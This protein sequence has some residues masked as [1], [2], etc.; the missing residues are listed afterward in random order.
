MSS[1]PYT[2]SDDGHGYGDVDDQSYIGGDYYDDYG[3]LAREYS[4]DDNLLLGDDVTSGTLRDN[5]LYD[6]DGWTCPDLYACTDFVEHPVPVYDAWGDESWEEE[7]V[8]AGTEDP[9]PLRF[10]EKLTR[11]DMQYALADLMVGPSSPA[12]PLVPPSS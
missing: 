4:P 11:R 5:R 2:I 7:Q 6:H 10:V 1:H 9:L 12:W 8:G 3:Y